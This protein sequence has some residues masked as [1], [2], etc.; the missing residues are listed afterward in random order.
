M[1]FFENYIRMK[2]KDNRILGLLSER[3]QKLDEI[4]LSYIST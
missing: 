2:T 3:L 4:N 1:N